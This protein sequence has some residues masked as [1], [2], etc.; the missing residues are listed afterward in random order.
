MRDLRGVSRTVRSLGMHEH[1]TLMSPDAG[2]PTA[3]GIS[4]GLPVVLLSQSA[5]RLRVLA[6]LYAFG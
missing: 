6:L 3:R 5:E 4:S 2:E 1:V